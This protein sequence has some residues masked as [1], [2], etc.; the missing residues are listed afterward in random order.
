M[1]RKTFVKMRKIKVF[2]F[3]FILTPFL[4]FSQNDN[5]I[6][7]QKANN[8]ITQ[9]KP[10]SAYHLFKKLERHVL[11]SDS[12]YPFLQANK[13]LS[14][15]ELEKES[16]M[17][18]NFQKSLDYNLE[19]MKAFQ[20]VKGK[21]SPDLQKKE[22]TVIKNIIISSFG[23]GDFERG[24]KWK[25]MLYKARNAGLLSGAMVSNFNFDFF[26]VDDLNVYGYEWF[27]E[28]PKSPYDKSNFTK[29]IYYVYNTN[30]D[31]SDKEQLYRLH[32]EK[33]NGTARKMDYVLSKKSGSGPNETSVT[34]YA[35]PYVKNIDYKKLQ[36]DVREIAGGNIKNYF[37]DNRKL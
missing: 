3:L 9:N 5:L 31:G 6:Q 13:V 34:L 30:S 7:F 33:F 2:T 16:R 22:Y 17:T 27:A 23:L 28:Y 12:L 25:A 15:I 1:T 21:M 35:Y 10:D 29:L 11:K 36:D 14:I 20:E 32:L 4:I 26:T 24:K 8:Y 37:K 18:E 19:A